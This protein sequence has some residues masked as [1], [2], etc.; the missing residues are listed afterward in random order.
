[1]NKLAL[2]WPL[3]DAYISNQ[4]L[5]SQK[6]VCKLAKLRLLREEVPVGIR[7]GQGSAG[8]PYR[9]IPPRFESRSTHVR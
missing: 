6:T 5:R 7:D 9:S 1:M 2:I 4:L 3:I 8:V